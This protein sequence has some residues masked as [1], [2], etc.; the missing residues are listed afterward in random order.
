MLFKDIDIFWQ[1]AQAILQ[2]RDPYSIPNLEV[3]YPLPFYFLF[4]P[5]VALPLPAVH[6]VWT[7]LQAVILV[8]SCADAPYSLRFRCQCF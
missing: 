7:A 5:L 6:A 8:P 2:G 1:A 4:V 3:F